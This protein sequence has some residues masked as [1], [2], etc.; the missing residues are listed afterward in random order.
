MRDV[1]HGALSSLR[2]FR[3]KVERTEV[4]GVVRRSID[5]VECDAEK[6]LLLN[7]VTSNIR[8]DRPVGKLDSFQIRDAVARGFAEAGSGPG[9]ISQAGRGPVKTP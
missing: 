6:A 1:L 8:L 4:D 7:V 3:P 2:I 9:R 5:A